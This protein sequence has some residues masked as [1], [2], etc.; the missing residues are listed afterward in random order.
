MEL[1]IKFTKGGVWPYTWILD[2]ETSHDL[3]TAMTKYKTTYQF[4]PP[5]NH[6]AKIAERD[7]QNF[8]S[9]FKAELVSVHLDFP[10]SE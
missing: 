9:I 4:V 10:I 1:Q 3:Q 5:H 6:R 8:K 7:I 2:H